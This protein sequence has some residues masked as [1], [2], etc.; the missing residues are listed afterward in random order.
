M[1]RKN[2]SR[3]QPLPEVLR[4][5]DPK[6]GITL[7]Q[8]QIEKGKELLS[9]RPLQ[10]SDHTAWDNTTR[11][12]LVRVFGSASPN[13]NAVL[14]ARSYDES[15]AAD[16]D[17]FEQDGDPR[18]VS[19]IKMLESC[20]DQLETEIELSGSS[21]SVS[22][23]SVSSMSMRESNRVFVVHGHNHGTKEAVARFI[24]KLGLDPVILHE[25][26]NAG[27]TIIEKFSDYSDVHFAVVLLTGD[28]E[29]RSRVEASSTR[30]RARQNVILELGFF[31]GKLGRSSDCAL[32]EEG[33]EIPSDYQGVL[34]VSLDATEKWR[35][36]LVKELKVAG[37]EIDANKIFSAD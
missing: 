5:V 15:Y 31:L 35:V 4:S 24:E 10:S 28:D 23:E 25:K 34:F 14:Y 6:T 37:F 13:V 26:P 27:R 2:I 16:Y 30:P 17:E 29:G 32:Y 20:I 19:Q 22:T 1:A 36:D 9:K 8:R 7:L 18:L 3:P 21:A 11:D 12:F 33:V